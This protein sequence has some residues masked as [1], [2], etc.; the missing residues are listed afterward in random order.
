[1]DDAV[2]KR[3]YTS[4]ETIS[5]TSNLV[6]DM[7]SMTK[8]EVPV[9]GHEVTYKGGTPISFQAH[10]PA[11]PGFPVISYSTGQI[12]DMRAQDQIY[13][14]DQG[15]VQVYENK[16]NKLQAEVNDL[17]NILSNHLLAMETLRRAWTQPALQANESLPKFRE[18]AEKI[19]LE[20][21]IP[22]NKYLAI[23]NSGELLAEAHTEL[24][25]LKKIQSLERDDIYIWKSG[26]D[27]VDAW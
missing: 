3:V 10:W 15:V 27:A 7:S 22:D 17:R 14:T 16:I 13:G 23:T 4:V 11:K 26:S 19:I 6:I 1:M 18:L 24:E 9:L 25:L 5:G 12:T 8:S 2:F 20:N 21:H